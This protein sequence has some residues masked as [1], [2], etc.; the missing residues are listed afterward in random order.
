MFIICFKFIVNIPLLAITAPK[1]QGSCLTQRLAANRYKK[2]ADVVIT[3]A[4]HKHS[5]LKKHHFRH[6]FYKTTML[7]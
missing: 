5:E 1:T 4:I 3:D 7:F 6:T 2:K